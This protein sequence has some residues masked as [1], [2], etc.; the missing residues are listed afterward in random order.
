MKGKNTEV[1][2]LLVEMEIAIDEIEAY[3][4]AINAD[5]QERKRR[6]TNIRTDIKDRFELGMLE[7]FDRTGMID[8]TVEVLLSDP[9][10]GL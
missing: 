6:L 7:E 2:D 3:R 5:I 10:R 4:R 8:Q 1:L 9:T